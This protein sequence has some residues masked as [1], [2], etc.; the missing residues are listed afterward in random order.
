[1][2]RRTTDPL[3]KDELCAE[4]PLR[5]AATLGHSLRLMLLE[6]FETSTCDDPN[7]PSCLDQRLIVQ[8]DC[9]LDLLGRA[10]KEEEK[11]S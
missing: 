1:M 4:R 3:E 6:E 11:A 10:I 5:Y 7:D 8:L 9:M 2:L